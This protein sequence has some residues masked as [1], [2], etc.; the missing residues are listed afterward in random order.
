MMDALDAIMQVM[1]ASF[2]PAYGE[3][4]NRRQVGDTLTMPGTFFL[5]ADG[6][7]AEPRAME[8]TRGFALSRAAAEE[9]ELL[10][11]A[12]MPQARGSG[13]GSA[14]MKRFLDCAQI[15]GS[16]RLFLEMRDGNPA[17]KLYQN[18][19]FEEV[20]RRINY[21]RSGID[22]PFDAITFATIRG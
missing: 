17:V 7:G 9:E 1:E 14:L 12:V 15:R 22:G 11:I 16:K 5:L 19:G 2:D 10:L 21:Y 8:D 6:N 4:W 13:V 18:H 20:G 3:A